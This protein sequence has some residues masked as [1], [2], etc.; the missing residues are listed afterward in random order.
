M[1]QLNSAPTAAS[2]D[3]DALT[4]KVVHLARSEREALVD[5]LHHLGEFDARRL[6][7]AQGYSSL[8]E[9]CSVF[10]RLSNG[11]AH[12]RY[13]TA[14]LMR[15]FPLIAE[16]LRA[17]RLNTKRVALLREVLTESNHAELLERATQGTEKDVERLVASLDP[18]PDVADGIRKLPSPRPLTAVASLVPMTAAP[19]PL[20]VTDGSARMALPLGSASRA[21]PPPD[22]SGSG[23]APTKLGSPT[24]TAHPPLEANGADPHTIIEEPPPAPRPHRMDIEATSGTTFSVRMS[25]GP[26][27]VAEFD[28]V[29]A[30]LSHKFPNGN[31]EAVMRECF[32]I[33]LEVVKRRRGAS[34]SSR[35]VRASSRAP[36]AS[37]SA[38]P[39]PAGTTSKNAT[40]GS[41]A[42]S[43]NATPEPHPATASK[44]SR[45]IPATVRQAVWSRDGGCCAFVSKDGRRCNS[46][47][48]VEVHHIEPYACGGPSTEE[49]LSLRCRQH[50]RHEAELAFGPDFMR[51]L[52]I[53]KCEDS[54]VPSLLVETA[55]ELEADGGLVA[56]KR[57]IG[58]TAPN[59]V[60]LH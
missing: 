53:W 20:P 2:L 46:K 8:F 12:R 30:A 38:T 22:S 33:T 29:K 6:Y 47:Y 40:A 58:A 4:K 52:R 28:E 57:S 5:F 42:A 49:N 19:P 41:A 26:E 14:R 31:F 10:L 39:A 50:N 7:L 32:R 60:D 37:A 11:T 13:T 17:G 48:Q 23:S 9:Y 54:A 35:T 56:G 36:S 24:T 59:P 34:A 21:L 44:P 16:F 45:Y 3:D 25:V 15:R 55:S 27:F 18:K 1:L 51:S 43:A